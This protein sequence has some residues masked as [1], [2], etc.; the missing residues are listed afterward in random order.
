MN[1]RSDKRIILLVDDQAA[2]IQVPH[3]ILKDSYALKI[4]TSGPRRW[5]LR[6]YCSNLTSCSWTSGC[7][8]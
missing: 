7:R 8:K 3:N 4:A 2:N 5:I 1:T 6:K